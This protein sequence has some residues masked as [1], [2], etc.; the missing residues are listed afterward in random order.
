MDLSRAARSRLIRPL[1]V[2]FA[3]SALAT[4]AFAQQTSTAVDS[5]A[6]R[7]CADPADMP[8]SNQKSEGF[9]NKI[10]ELIA[11][12][13]GVP[14]RYEWYPE[15]TGFVRRTLQDGKCDVII[16]YP[17]GN[18]EV[19]STNPYYKSAWVMVTKKGSPLNDVKNLDDPRLK[20]ARLG[21]QGGAPP[22]NAM[23][24]NG[25]MRKAKSSY[26]LM[27]DRRYGSAPDDMMADLQSG[28]IDL[29]ILWGPIASYFA[30][31]GNMDVV[32]TP[33][34]HETKGPKLS[35]YIAM[36]VR[37]HD[38]EWKRK[39]NAILTT[40]AD[41]IKKILLSYGVPLLDDSDNVMTP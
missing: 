13:L 18:D 23:A 37:S 10:A 12:D 14:V 4:A 3:C 26:G 1:V 33:M 28:E 38:Q 30:K 19:T 41:E 27:E 17:Q 29:A 11:K 31:K 40:H 22:G 7:V 34:I 9:E 21:I 6:L 20:D 16:G 32:I 15:A 2:V 35:Y 5:S 36:G 25:L 8:A 39:L 24:L